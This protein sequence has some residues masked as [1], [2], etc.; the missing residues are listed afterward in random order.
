MG[1]IR[2]YPVKSFR[3][4]ESVV[5]RSLKKQR[6]EN[7]KWYGAEFRFY[8]S[9]YCKNGE[10][11]KMDT[12]NLIKYAEDAVMKYVECR[13]E[14]GYECIDDSRIVEITAEKIDS[15]EEKTEIILYCVGNGD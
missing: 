4:W 10:V 14:N 13:G 2:K 15:V 3:D 6:I 9:V 7:C 5:R 11:R 8:L 12:S 1:R